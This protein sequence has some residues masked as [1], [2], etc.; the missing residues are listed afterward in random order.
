MILFQPSGGQMTVNETYIVDNDGKTS[1]NDPAGA[2]HVWVP[3]A[4]KGKA[5]V[6]GAAA[7]A[8]GMGI[9]AAIVKS[10]APDVFGVN[11]PIKPGETRIDID[12]TV[13]YTAIG[14]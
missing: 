12:Y 10:Q 5:E 6:N 3:A 11:F 14:R 4:A 1:W 7:D 13:P 2:L 8:N 9:A